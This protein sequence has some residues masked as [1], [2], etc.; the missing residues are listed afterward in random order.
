MHLLFGIPTDVWNVFLAFKDKRKPEIF[1][2]HTCVW[3]V[4]LKMFRQKWK[5]MGTASL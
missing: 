1:A 3:P 2:M 4:A 5:K